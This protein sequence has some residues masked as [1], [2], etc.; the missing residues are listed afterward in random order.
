M[1]APVRASLSLVAGHPLRIVDYLDADSAV[2]RLDRVER[3]LLVVAPQQTAVVVSSSR[4]LAMVVKE[5]IDISPPVFVFSQISREEEE[6]EKPALKIYWRCPRPRDYSSAFVEDRTENGFWT[7]EEPRLGFSTAL[8]DGVY[9]RDLGLHHRLSIR[10]DNLVVTSFRPD[11]TKTIEVKVPFDSFLP[12]CRIFTRMLVVDDYFVLVC[13]WRGYALIHRSTG[14]VQVF[15]GLQL[16]RLDEGL[17]PADVFVALRR[18]PDT[19]EGWRMYRRP[20]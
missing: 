8:M 1:S 10:G 6:E 20:G 9:D 11:C 13:T 4:T 16:A 7:G 15:K 17:C 14:E 12:T 18:G 3:T 5:K 19:T 2:G